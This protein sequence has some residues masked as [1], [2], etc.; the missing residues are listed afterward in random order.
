MENDQELRELLL[1]CAQRL[2]VLYTQVQDT[3]MAAGVDLM[4]SASAIYRTLKA[5]GEDGGLHTTL[6]ALGQRF[7]RPSRTARE[8]QQD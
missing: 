1:I 5:N 4:K 7:D 2:G 8:T 3:A 6:N